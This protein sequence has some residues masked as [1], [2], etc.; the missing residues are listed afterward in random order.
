MKTLKQEIQYIQRKV[1]GWTPLD[2]LLSLAI[3]AKGSEYILGDILEVGTWCGRSAIVLA[4]AC[5]QSTVYTIDLF[6]EKDDWHQHPNGSWGFKTQIGALVHYGYQDQT[7]YDEAFQKTI[8]P[9]YER[10]NSPIEAVIEF[11]EKFK[12][13]NL[14]L[15]RT[16]SG[17]MSIHPN[18]RFRLVFIDADHSYDAVCKDIDNVEQRLAI[19]GW[20]CFDDA[21]RKDYPYEGLDRAVTEKILNNPRFD[22]KGN[23][24]K[25]LF[26]ARKLY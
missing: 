2:Q 25:K 9:V 8:V 19:G 12:L 24:T 21:F 22:H 16:T 17:G 23:L 20:I 5:P 3:L 4:K 26:V 14:V 1:P 18:R 10:W 6:P 7:V 13:T 11:R 15:E